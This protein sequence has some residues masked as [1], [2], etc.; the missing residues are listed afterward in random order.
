MIRL[1]W[2]RRL[3]YMRLL[4]AKYTELLKAKKYAS[5]EKVAILFKKLT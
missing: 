3:A 5:A 4:S 2:R 1:T